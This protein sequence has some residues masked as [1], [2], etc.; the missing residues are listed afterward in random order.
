MAGPTPERSGPM[1]CAAIKY[2]KNLL[3]A[4]SGSIAAGRGGVP[5]LPRSGGSARPG[6]TSGPLPPHR[7]S[8]RTPPGATS[9]PG[10]ATTA[11]LAGRTV[12]GRAL[13]LD[14]PTDGGP[15]AAARLPRSVVDSQALPVAAGLV[16]EGAIGAEG[17]SHAPD[18]LAE[19]PGRPGRDRLPLL[20]R[21]RSRAPPRFH[22]GAV[23]DL[24]RVD[25]AD[26]GEPSLVE[27]EILD[28]RAR[29]ARER[30][31]ELPGGRRE[32]RIGTQDRERG[33]GRETRGAS[34]PQEPEAARI[35]E[36]QR[37]LVGEAQDRVDVLERL[38]RLPGAHAPASAHAQVRE[39]REAAAQIDE[40][41][42]AEPSHG[43]DSQ[44]PQ[45]ARGCASVAPHGMLRRS[46][47]SLLK[48]GWTPH[49]GSFALRRVCPPRHRATQPA[50]A[51]PGHPRRPRR[52]RAHLGGGSRRPRGGGE[53]DPLHRPGGRA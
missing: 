22:T 47:T 51:R 14:D 4:R 39:E 24:A 19:H 13:A 33:I 10:S 20:A 42:F 27:Q 5:R 25:I 31:E 26:P 1:G 34:Q 21:E 17:G 41:V 49:A 50:H 15:A 32:E 12:E 44:A 46:R 7:T 23:E 28:A 53:G 45:G 38:R 9:V 6:P 16:P 35:L 30:G 29:A 37:A 52:A 36:D 3:G 40:Q 11:G 43:S 8:A 18:R 48:T 2:P